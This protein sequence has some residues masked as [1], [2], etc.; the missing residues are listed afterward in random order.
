MKH[1]KVRIIQIVLALALGAFAFSPAQARAASAAQIAAD[2]R[3]VLRNLYSRNSKARMLGAHA[4]AVL[5]F[6]R[7]TKGG[8]LVAVQHGDGALFQGNRVVGYYNSVA[9]SYGFQAG[10][11]QFGYALFFMNNRSLSYLNSA[12]GWNV[13]TAPSL[14]VMD[15]GMSGSIGT[16]SLDKEIY[17]MFFDQRG[18]MGGLGLQGSKIS[19]ISPN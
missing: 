16:L 15:K 19:R 8:F 5:I 12:G 4:R 1:C 7:I 2:S 14:V 18:L 17:A 3:T 13:G 10:V 6:P 9:G 11:Q